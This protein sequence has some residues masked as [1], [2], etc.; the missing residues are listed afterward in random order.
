[1]AGVDGEEFGCAGFAVGVYDFDLVVLIEFEVF[2]D[3]DAA[4]AV[5][6]CWCCYLM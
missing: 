6:G 5:G 2:D 4:L 1:M 3:G